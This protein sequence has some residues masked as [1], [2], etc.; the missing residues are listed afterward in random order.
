[1]ADNEHI[2][3]K[4]Q[5]LRYEVG[6]TV[7]PG[8]RLGR[9][10]HAIVDSGDLSETNPNNRLRSAVPQVVLKA[11]PGTYIRGG[12]LFASVAGTLNVDRS[13]VNQPSNE[14]DSASSTITVSVRP[15]RGFRALMQVLRQDQTVLARVVR[16]ATQQIIVDIVANQNGLLD[17]IASGC[18]RRE[19]VNSRA[20]QATEPTEAVTAAVLTQYFRPGDWIVARIISLGDEHRYYLSTAEPAL[21]VIHAVSAVSGIP[22]L[23]VSWKEMECPETSKKEPR[24]CARPQRLANAPVARKALKLAGVSMG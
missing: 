9:A 2:P 14:T 15:K 3:P 22:M 8:D 1:M 23:P 19:D 5:G 18:I 17:S 10:A 13:N 12:H 21:G 4:G 20:Q 7:V 16:I 6:S 24:K 11:G